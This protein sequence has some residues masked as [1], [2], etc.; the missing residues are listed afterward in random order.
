LPQ[1]VKY[2]I[3]LAYP[4]KNQLKTLNRQNFATYKEIGVKE[5]NAEVRNFYRK[6]LNSRFCARAV[7]SMVKIVPNAAKSKKSIHVKYRTLRTMVT[8]DF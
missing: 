5:S 6:L 1:T 2:G 8:A 3:L 4:I 7:K